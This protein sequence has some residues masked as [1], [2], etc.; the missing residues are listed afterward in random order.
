MAAQVQRRS[1]FPGFKIP[2]GR[3]LWSTRYF[4]ACHA[5]NRATTRAI[6]GDVSPF[7]TRFGMVPQSSTPFLKPGYV[8]TERQD[9]LK[10]K[11]RFLVFFVRRPS[12][13]RPRNTLFK[14]FAL[15][16]EYRTLSKRHMGTCT[17]CILVSAENVASVPVTRRGE[18]AGVLRVVQEDTDLEEPRQFKFELSEPT[19]LRSGANGISLS[20]ASG[21][22]PTP[23][24]FPCGRASPASMQSTATAI[25]VRGAAIK[26]FL[27]APGEGAASDLAKSHVQSCAGTR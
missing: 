13:N 23:V 27:D 12:P 24:A 4:W 19:Y 9:R 25:S 22:T 20:I 8:K 26:E 7:K 21:N 18:G 2:S 16:G 17:R 6:V 10:S 1:L 15:F 3:I 11:A 14:Y 5:L